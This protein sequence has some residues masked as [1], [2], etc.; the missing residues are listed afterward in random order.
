MI[1]PIGNITIQQPDP[2]SVASMIL[3]EFFHEPHRRPPA[4]SA[5][6]LGN[7]GN[8]DRLKMPTKRMPSPQLKPV[9]TDHPLVSFHHRYW[10]GQ[11]TSP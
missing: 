3:D 6:L 7:Y 9:P 8:D 4:T 5:N 2:P 11:P 1:H 10:M